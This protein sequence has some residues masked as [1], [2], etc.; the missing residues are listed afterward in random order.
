MSN[1]ARTRLAAAALALALVTPLG[2]CEGGAEGEAC[3]VEAG[4]D[5]C[6]VDHH[7]GIRSCAPDYPGSEDGTWSACLID[8]CAEEGATR[9]CADGDDEGQQFCVAVDGERRWG[10]C[11]VEPECTV[12][13]S[14]PCFPDAPEFQG[15]NQVCALNP[16]GAPEW[17]GECLTP[18][19][20]SFDR[21]EPTFT[22]PGPAAARFD[23]TG[24][25]RCDDPQWP[26]AA[27]PWLVLDRDQSGTIDGGELFG[28][29]T[30]LASGDRAPHGFAALAELD[31][32]HDGIV[33]ARDPG[34]AGLML[35]SDHDGDRRSTPWELTPIA[36]HGVEAIDLDFRRDARC[37]AAGNCGVERSSFAFRSDEGV[38]EGAVID[39]YLACE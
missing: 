33:D 35:W 38:R 1:A 12:G 27:T 15:V 11:V 13:A 34:F 16:S 29:G 4:H 3:V 9:S 6:W 23:V 10:A 21:R 24:R 26:S 20:L 25:G 30:R 17:M 22:A 32:N 39:V 2:A 14:T 28:N 19:V 31:R 36:A 37:D 18:L 7:R 5:A 8:E